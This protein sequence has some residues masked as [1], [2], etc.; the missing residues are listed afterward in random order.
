M[1]IDYYKLLEASPEASADEIKRAYRKQALLWHPDKHPNEDVTDRMRDI[2]EAYAILKDSEKRK[3]YD[4]AYRRFM[5]E[6]SND[7][8][9]DT[10]RCSNFRYNYDTG[11]D[12][13]NDDIADA[14]AYA[15]S[16][17]DKFFEELKRNSQTAAQGAWN[18]SKAYI[19]VGILWF[20]IGLMVKSCAS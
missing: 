6:T 8:A 11:D 3:R 4:A 20:I 13:L 15:Q 5:A 12:E 19:V 9:S 2:N 10:G 18:K 16:L 1:F 17:V 14:R 7:V